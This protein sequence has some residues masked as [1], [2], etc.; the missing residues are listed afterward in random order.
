ML[1]F[2]LDIFSALGMSQWPSGIRLPS[3]ELLVSPTLDW[4]F[5]RAKRQ[6]S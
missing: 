6:V 5:R 2:A 3:R 1:E 4:L